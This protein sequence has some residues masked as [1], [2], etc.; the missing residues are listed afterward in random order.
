VSST[1]RRI[2]LSHNPPLELD[3]EC[4][5][6]VPPEQP[7]DHPNCKI[8]LGRYSYPLIEVWLPTPYYDGQS[9]AGR[10]YD[11]SWMRAFAPLARWIADER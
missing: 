2:C 11:T 7:M 3:E 5:A 1:Y 6:T 10:W 9:H 4:A 8:A